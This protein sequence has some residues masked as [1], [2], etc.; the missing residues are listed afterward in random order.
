MGNVFLV[1]PPG[2]VDSFAIFHVCLYEVFA[3]ETATQS[4]VSFYLHSREMGMVVVFYV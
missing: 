2:R 1:P 3:S 4:A